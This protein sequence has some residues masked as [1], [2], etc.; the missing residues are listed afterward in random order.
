MTRMRAVFYRDPAGTE[1][2]RHFLATLPAP[3]RATVL[4]QLDRLNTLT[5]NDPPLPFPHSSQVADEL[6]ELRCHYG[7][8][9]F[10]ILYRRS[11]TLFVLL[12]A[13]EKTTPAVP[14]AETALAQLRWEDF[15]RRMSKVPRRPPRAAGHDAP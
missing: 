13:F 8:R 4:L 10:R 15:H 7:R 1:P 3:A 6:R 14:E 2:V 11:E 12:H 5:D 9:L